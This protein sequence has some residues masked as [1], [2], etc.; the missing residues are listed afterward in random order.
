[1]DLT[2]EVF[3]AGFSALDRYD[4]DRPF[5]TWIAHIALNKC[6]DWARRRKVRAFFSRALPLESA[7]HIASDGP[8]PASVA[9]GRRELPRVR[10]G[11][12]QLPQGLRRGILLARKRVGVG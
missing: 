1:M 11:K 8:A 7:H 4:V 6:H 10:G 12:D 5:R 2:Q 9:T 3:V